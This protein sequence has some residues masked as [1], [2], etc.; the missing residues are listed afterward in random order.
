MIT[1]EGVE[2]PCGDRTLAE[3][4]DEVIHEEENRHQYW[5]NRR[6]LIGTIVVLALECV[7]K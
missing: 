5:E 1:S 7:V 4:V 3:T 6:V 2:N